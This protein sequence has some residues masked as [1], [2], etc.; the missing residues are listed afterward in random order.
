M[1]ETARWK[2]NPC[3]FFFFEYWSKTSFISE[4]SSTFLFLLFSSLHF[5]EWYQKYIF[6]KCHKRFE[7]KSASLERR[8]Q[9]KIVIQKKNGL[10][11]N[12]S[13]YKERYAC[14]ITQPETCKIFLDRKKADHF[15]RWERVLLHYFSRGGHL[16]R[17]S[18]I[19]P[20]ESAVNW[21]FVVLFDESFSRIHLMVI[22][23][24]FMRIFSRTNKYIITFLKF[25]RHCHYNSNRCLSAASMELISVI[26]NT[27]T[28]ILYKFLNV[29]R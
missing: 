27:H 11:P 1:K 23:E 8:K 24:H 9:L 26:N 2:Q 3:I 20:G 28:L 29:V 13:E 21:P 16:P 22:Y 10:I 7:A 4:L 17:P 15:D 19:G 14:D 6:K 18:S 12:D 5:L 25:H